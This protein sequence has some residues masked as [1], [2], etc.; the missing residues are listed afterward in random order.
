MRTYFLNLRTGIMFKDNNYTNLSFF[1]NIIK[2]ILRISL[3]LLALF[4]NNLFILLLIK[5]QIVER[6]WIMLNLFLISSIYISLSF[7][8]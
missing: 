2:I 5:Q 3:F 8:I 1:R 4:N 7:L 6:T